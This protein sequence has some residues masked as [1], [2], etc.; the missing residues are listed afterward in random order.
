MKVLVINDYARKGGAEEVYHASVDVLRAQPGIEVLQFDETT[1]GVTASGAA[2]AWNTGAAR[3]LAD[4]LERERPERVLVHNYHNLLSPSILPVLA[5]YRR[6]SGC[7]TLLTCHD[8][9]LVYYNPSLLTYPD[10][11]P[12]PLPL[13]AIARGSLL[14]RR[15]SPRGALHDVMKKLHWHAVQTFVHPAR[16]FDLLLCPSPYMREALARRGLTHTVLL[17]NPV[18]TS[19]TPGAP[20]CKA[21]ERF[22]LAFV[23]RIDHEKGLGEFLALADATRFEKIASVTVY[24]DGGERAALERRHA[25][26][27]AAGRLRFAGR[28]DQASLFAALRHHD[29]LVLPSVWAENAPLV[30]VEAAMLGLPVLVHDIGSL[31]SFGDEIGNKI[32]YTQTADSLGRALDTLGAHLRDPNRRYDWSLYTRRHY[33]ASL[34]AA[35]ELNTADVDE[36]TPQCI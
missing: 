21:R 24:G 13:D 23:G 35:L 16:A 33:A 27:I 11:R 26:L 6:R 4:I 5:R 1:P 34:S 17:H 30:I 29:A 36:L 28:L 15:S 9:H 10:G 8:Y 7:R 18:S 14:L 19:L 32:R 22:D 2:R 12:T 20:V 25:D 3:A 31:S